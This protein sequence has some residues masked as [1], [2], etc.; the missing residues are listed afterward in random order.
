MTDSISDDPP[1]AAL[2]YASGPGARPR[3]GAPIGANPAGA[4]E[5][6]GDREALVD[7][8]SGRRWTYAEFG[9]S[10]EAVA[11]GLMAKG[12]DKGDRVGIW[13]V[14]CP[15]WV[16]VQYATARIGAIMVN[17]NPAYRA[18]ELAY[19]LKQSGVSVLIS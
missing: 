9:R 11:L 2:S 16:L 14:N 18:H 15:E 12:V 6:H 5:R 3:R 17:L 13:A 4:V 7:V 10:V 19:V 8:P 1:P